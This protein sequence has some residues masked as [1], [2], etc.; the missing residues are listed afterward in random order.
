[1]TDPEMDLVGN[2]DAMEWAEAW[3]ARMARLS[4]A[5][6]SEFV[7]SRGTMVGWFAN[8]IEA[9]RGAATGRTLRTMNETET[10]TTTTTETV[11]TPEPAEPTQPVEP[12][13]PDDDRDDDDGRDS[14]DDK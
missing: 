13:E 14:D 2:T 4:P 3:C 12:A 5:Q 7:T 1:M 6:R 10:T 9:G 8:A 11:D